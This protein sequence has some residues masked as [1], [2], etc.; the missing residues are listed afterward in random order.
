MIKGRGGASLL[1]FG[2][3]PA[4]HRT[5]LVGWVERCGGLAEHR[6]THR[7][8]FARIKT[9]SAHLLPLPA[10][11]RGPGERFRGRW[12]GGPNLSPPTPLPEAGRG[13]QV[14]YRSPTWG[15]R[16]WWVERSCAEP[17]DRSTHPTKLIPTC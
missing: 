2:I 16:F 10:S 14:G 15:R 1:S 13:E 11:G 4:L 17:P 3:S 8:R 12:V 6:A 9:T 5:G 7:E